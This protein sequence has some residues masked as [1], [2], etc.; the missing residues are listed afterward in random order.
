LD[1][2]TQ[3]LVARS[4]RCSFWGK[5]QFHPGF[6]ARRSFGGGESEQ[7][8]QILEVTKSDGSFATGLA[9]LP[10]L[11]TVS[12][13]RMGGSSLD[14]IGAACAVKAAGLAPICRRVEAAT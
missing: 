6:T 14:R 2:A 1:S 13:L 9:T 5:L 11:A 3:V 12:V 8:H 7:V 4:L 10:G